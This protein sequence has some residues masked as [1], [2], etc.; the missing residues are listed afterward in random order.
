L[1]INYKNTPIREPESRMAGRWAIFLLLLVWVPT[2]YGCT[3]HSRTGPIKIDTRGEVAPI[4]VDELTLITWNIAKN[5]RGNDEIHRLVSDHSPDILLIQEGISGTCDLFGDS[6]HQCLFAPSWKMT[7]HDIY[8]GVKVLSRFHLEHPVH[9]PS[10][11]LEGF[12]FTPK[13]S[14]IATLDLPAGGQL[15]LINVHMLNFVPLSHLE[16][17]LD[18]IY[19]HAADHAGPMLMGGDFNTWNNTRLMAVEQFAAKLGM[20]E[21]FAYYETTAGGT[22]PDWLFFLTPFMHLDLDSPLDRWF[23][24]GIEVISCRYLDGFISSDHAP[25]LLQ[26]RLNHQ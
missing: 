7:S 25:I 4:I 23:Y 3:P 12:I 9:V 17:Y 18:T 11:T 22:P 1:S 13:A 19:E 24:R 10:P 20:V 26:V 2:N 14:I 16:S 15:M 8:T 5:I 6:F 21:A